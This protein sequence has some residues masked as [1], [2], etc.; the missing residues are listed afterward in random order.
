[1]SLMSLWKNYRAKQQEKSALKCGDTLNNKVTTKEQ[2][3]EAIESLAGMSPE[4]ALPQLLKRFEL[5]V[6]HGIQD[7]REKEMVEKIFLDQKDAAL[8]V[9]RSA[10][11]HSARVSWPIRL[12]EK[13]FAEAEYKSLLL[14]AVVTQSAL[15]DDTVLER[16]VELLLALRELPDEKVIE[17][18]AALLSSRDENVRLAALECLEFQ[19]ASSAQAKKI[20]LSLMNDPATD[21]NSRFK[22]LIQN[23]IQKHNW[24][25]A[26]ESVTHA[27]S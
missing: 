12:A 10:V 2:R 20:V 21:A 13:L 6:D 11:M 17:K 18:A 15:F 5:V 9:V 8:S 14:D 22:G 3:M 7:N 27:P 26:E 24:A 4:V 23:I 1:M 19:G 25:V 16:N